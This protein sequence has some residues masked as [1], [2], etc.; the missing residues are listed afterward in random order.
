MLG[1]AGPLGIDPFSPHSENARL[2]ALASSIALPLAG[3]TV[4]LSLGRFVLQ[5][6]TSPVAW[7]ALGCAGMFVLAKLALSQ[8]PDRATGRFLIPLTG[9]IG[10][11]AI[12]GLEEG[13]Y[14]EAMLFVPFVPLVAA[15][16]CHR[17]AAIGLTVGS[18]TG[19]A[20][21]GMLHLGGFIGIAHERDRLLFHLFAASG[22]TAF[23][24]V[25]AIGYASYRL[26]TEQRL[27][28][29][30]THDRATGLPA[31][32]L[33]RDAMAAALASAKTTNS[34]VAVIVLELRNLAQLRRQHGFDAAAV[35]ARSI[36]GRIR[37]SAHV[38]ET[39]GLLAEGLYV[40]VVP[41]ATPT[42]VGDV[43]SH[44]RSAFSKDL[45]VGPEP[46]K[47]DA[48]IGKA[49]SAEDDTP[50]SLLERASDDARR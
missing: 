31:W 37:A 33:V 41:E 8:S 27:W 15:M 42:L 34:R 11:M 39:P 47:L 29:A 6:A 10:T 44:L 23:A 22:A 17:Q 40:V 36:A 24:G 19:V 49:F 28:K 38:G 5:G 21:L 25:L 45:A 4:F 18:V 16:T 14:S 7:V 43:V 9:L 46:V 35:A 13:M 3:V 30:E 50:L 12:A 1:L 26:R 20:L 32:E 48:H 2:T